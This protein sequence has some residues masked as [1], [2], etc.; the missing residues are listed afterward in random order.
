[1]YS[2]HQVV[3]CVERERERGAEREREGKR[4]REIER[5]SVC[6]RESAH[7]E[8]TQSE[9]LPCSMTVHPHEHVYACYCA[10]KCSYAQSMYIYINIYISMLVQ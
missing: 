4:E 3:L 2:I 7:A 9:H 8:R 1:M 5:A 10:F 6:E